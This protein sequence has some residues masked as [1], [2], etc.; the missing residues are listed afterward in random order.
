MWPGREG[1]AHM[2]VNIET[3]AHT[4]SVYVHVCLE[5]KQWMR[6]YMYGQIISAACVHAG[7]RGVF[8]CVPCM[9]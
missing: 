4:F 6:V 8:V 9:Q 3:Y 1:Y 2:H 5:E 7:G